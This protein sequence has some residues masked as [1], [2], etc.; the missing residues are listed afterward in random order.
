MID[1]EFTWK[2]LR[3]VWNGRRRAWLCERRREQS[4][5]WW[6]THHLFERSFYLREQDNG[7]DWESPP[8]PELPQLQ[9]FV[10]GGYLAHFGHGDAA[11]RPTR[12]EALEAALGY[13][14]RY[15][16][17]CLAALRGVLFATEISA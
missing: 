17:R 11:L 9:G 6:V 1:K 10:N 4:D 8:S 2:G 13:A 16:H 12:A 5:D 15:H 7:I 14:L 3:F